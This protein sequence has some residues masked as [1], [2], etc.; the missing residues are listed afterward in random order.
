MFSREKL[1]NGLQK[2]FEKRPVSQEVIEDMVDQIE[3]A[4]RKKGK[5]VKSSVIGEMIMRKLS[6]VDQIAYIRFASVYKDFKDPKD[7]K[8][9][10][11]K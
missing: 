1:A 6:K 8:E 3:S 5:E 7:F 2:A 11:G 10:L 4:L 9:I